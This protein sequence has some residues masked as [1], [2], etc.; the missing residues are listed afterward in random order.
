[1][2][3]QRYQTRAQ[4]QVEVDKM[5]GWTTKIE[6]AVVL[7]DAGTKLATVYVIRCDGTKYLRTDGY[8]R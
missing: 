4:A 1:M 7:N 6:R 8:V 3:K 5:R 2:D